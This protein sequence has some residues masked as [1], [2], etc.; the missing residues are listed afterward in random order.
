MVVKIE[1]QIFCKCLISKPRDLLSINFSGFVAN[2]FTIKNIKKME[3]S[4]FQTSI[5]FLNLTSFY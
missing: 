4:T 1:I 3:S 5:S 2:G